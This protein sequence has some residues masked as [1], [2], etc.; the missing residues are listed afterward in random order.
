VVAPRFDDAETR[1]ALWDAIG[2]QLTLVAYGGSPPIIGEKWQ[3]EGILGRGG[4]GLVCAARDN[5]LPRRVAIKLFP[6]GPEL[7]FLMREARSLALLEHPAIVT[8]IEVDNGMVRCGERSIPCGWIVMPLI[9]GETLDGW[10]KQARPRAAAVVDII[11]TVGRALAHAHA[12]GVLHRD[13]KPANIM[14]D[15]RGRPF[16]I[17]FGL[18][19]GTP[20]SIADERMG[21]EPPVDALGERATSAGAVRG[22]PS[23]MAPEAVD[24]QPSAGSDQFA[25]AVVAWE[26]L[27]GVHPWRAIDAAPRSIGP[28]RVASWQRER[29]VPVLER[30]MESRPATRFANMNAFCDAL[31]TAVSSRWRRRVAS[32]G[33]V[34]L[35][36]AGLVGGAYWAGWVRGSPEDSASAS[37]AAMVRSVPACDGLSAWAGHWSLMGRIVWTEY[38]NQLVQVRPI[39]LNVDVLD[40]CNVRV[41]MDKFLPADATSSDEF[42]AGEATVTPIRVGNT[43]WLVAYE[44]EFVGDRR[45]Y[46]E[47]EH[48][49]FALTLDRSPD[50]EPLVRGAFAKVQTAGGLVLRKGWVLGRRDRSPTL[51]EVDAHEFPC[52]ARCR[53]H[54]AGDEATRACIERQCAPYAEPLEDPC[55]PPSN[56]FV[57]PL[58]T[59]VERRQ[60]RRGRRF[61]GIATGEP[62]DCE[63]NATRVLG[64]WGL[65]R[66]TEAG[67]ELARLDVV[68]QGCRLHASLRGA[69]GVVSMSGEIT[70][71]GIWYLAPDPPAPVDETLVLAGTGPAFGID[72]AEPGRLVRVFR[73]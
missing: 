68:P 11:D 36:A 61:G 53:I 58:R 49:E 19:I 20:T 14:I 66:P 73:P 2:T 13:L 27:F 33:I 43:S 56:D 4:F 16:V 71:M 29:L 55:G 32:A 21:R 17:D 8:I 41:Q 46:G 63:Q 59:R 54:C 6:S 42:L 3:L 18:A 62:G 72:L 45:T 26:A 7:V 47:K 70:Q 37:P 67:H 64:Q 65:W 28:V 52:D 34:V 69:E 9:D 10:V 50:G 40:E 12:K 35:L 31:A 38:S 15:A 5:K 22:T 23:Y 1:N 57:A 60:L 48:H 44:L 51:D 25:L 39:G 24:G 30:G